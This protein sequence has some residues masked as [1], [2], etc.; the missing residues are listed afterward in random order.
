MEPHTNHLLRRGFGSKLFSQL[1]V[2]HLFKVSLALLADL[3]RRS[4]SATHD[5]SGIPDKSEA[6]AFDA[7]ATS[8]HTSME[9]VQ[10]DKSSSPSSSP[11]HDVK[12]QALRMPG[13]TIVALPPSHLP[14]GQS[15]YTFPTPAQMLAAVPSRPSTSQAGHHAVQLENPHLPPVDPDNVNTW[16]SLKVLGHAEPVNIVGRPVVIHKEMLSPSTREKLLY[17]HGPRPKSNE[18]RVETSY[19]PAS[20]KLVVFG[21]PPNF[22]IRTLSPNSRKILKDSYLDKSRPWR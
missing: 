1:K 8:D 3:C 16:R 22:D 9:D 20:G 15:S 17:S 5:P 4:Q 12:R 10:Q 21:R 14:A 6:S 18:I 13:P 19:Q 11:V 2:R 7:L